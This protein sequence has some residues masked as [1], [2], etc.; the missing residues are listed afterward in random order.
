MKR[1]VCS[2]AL[3]CVIAA[4]IHPGHA[5]SLVRRALRHAHAPP[6]LLTL[7]THTQRALPM[8]KYPSDGTYHYYDASRD[9]KSPT[10]VKTT[11]RYRWRTQVADRWETGQPIPQDLPPGEVPQ[12]VQG[13]PADFWP[14]PINIPPYKSEP[15]EGVMEG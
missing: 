2:I 13:V 14:N 9:R 12:T 10:F 3:L 8:D 11:L 4:C 6:H 5:Q 7:V 15:A 1:L